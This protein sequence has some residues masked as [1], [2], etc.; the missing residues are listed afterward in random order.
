MF[1]VLFDEQKVILEL[2]KRS[3]N[4]GYMLTPTEKNKPQVGWK[5]N[6]CLK[7]MRLSSTDLGRCVICNSANLEELFGYTDFKIAQRQTRGIH[8]N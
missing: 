3:F 7:V 1:H 2:A 6:V 8:V 4:N 5:C